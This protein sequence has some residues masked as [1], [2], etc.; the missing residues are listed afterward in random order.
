MLVEQEVHGLHGHR[1]RKHTH[2]HMYVILEVINLLCPNRK[3]VLCVIVIMTRR[4][5]KLL[6]L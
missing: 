2:S 1:A 4:I 5:S 3:K 6:S